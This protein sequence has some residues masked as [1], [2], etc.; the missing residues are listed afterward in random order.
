MYHF[1]S[2]HMLKLNKKLVLLDT[3]RKREEVG[4]QVLLDSKRKRE[5]MEG[6]KYELM[7]YSLDA[8]C[9]M[10][11]MDWWY[12]ISMGVCKT[13][14][15]SDMHP[16]ILIDGRDNNCFAHVQVIIIMVCIM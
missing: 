3:K 11:E 9:S 5:E 14:L 8:H 12:I 1:C 15:H 7:I 13:E 16:D 2:T 4:G 10:P 6:L